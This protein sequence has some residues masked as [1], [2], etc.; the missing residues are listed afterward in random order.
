MVFSPSEEYCKSLFNLYVKRN[1]KD[2]SVNQGESSRDNELL[3]KD[4]Q[5]Q[6]HTLI[7]ATLRGRLSEGIEILDKQ[8]RASKVRMIIITG[9][10]LPPPTNYQ[11]LLEHK[12]AKRWGTKESLIFLRWMSVFQLLLQAVG[13]G[14]RR[15][16]D[17]CAIVCLDNRIPKL[18]VFSKELSFVTNNWKLLVAKLQQFYREQE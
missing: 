17:H 13:R 8:T 12:Y 9:V 2:N 14:I 5:E 6:D 7:F 15:P 1:L 3:L 11:Q 4:L 16:T 10:P 18:A